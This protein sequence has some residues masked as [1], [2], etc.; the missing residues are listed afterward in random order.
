M[1]SQ[2]AS[3]ARAAAIGEIITDGDI[4]S[5]NTALADRGID[6]DQILSIL[7]IAAQNLVTIAPAKFRVLYRKRG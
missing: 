4:D 5:L 1:P 2:S 6:A 7:P 3:A